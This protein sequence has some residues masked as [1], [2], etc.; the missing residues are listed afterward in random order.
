MPCDQHCAACVTLC[1]M[2][3]K[4]PILG[5][6]RKKAWR[7]QAERR[8][9]AAEARA[10]ELGQEIC[11]NEDG[12]PYWGSRNAG[13]WTALHGQSATSTPGASIPHLP[14]IEALPLPHHLPPSVA[15]HLRALGLCHTGAA[16]PS[17]SRH[18]YLLPV[19]VITALPG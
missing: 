9:A 2:H 12:N 18:F 14:P 15:Y 19:L 7:K 3:V 16:Y 13:Y 8:D 17:R 10:Y 4:N 6:F 5:Y 1:G 11:W